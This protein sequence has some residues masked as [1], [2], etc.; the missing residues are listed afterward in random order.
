[1][2]TDGSN[3][4]LSQN[5]DLGESGLEKTI[6][7]RDREDGVGEK[8]FSS[9]TNSTR[10]SRN[11]S[12]LIVTPPGFEEDDANISHLRRHTHT[13]TDTDGWTGP[14]LGTRQLEKYLHEKLALI[15]V[16]TWNMGSLPLPSEHQLFKLFHHEYENFKNIDV[17]VVAV[18]EC[19]PDVDAWE[20]E[21]QMCLG[22]EF[23]L[24]HSISYGTLHLSVFLRR[25][26]LWFTTGRNE[27]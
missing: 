20:L 6:Q 19:W 4:A 16:T 27:K 2:R 9:S 25:D 18:Q 1:V 14:L 15:Q 11:V 23:A 22:A 21:L 3:S 24:F 17:H 13:S 10:P 7:E 12:P 5:E 8:E 26:L